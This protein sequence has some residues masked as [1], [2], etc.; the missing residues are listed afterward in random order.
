MGSSFH[1]LSSAKAAKDGLMIIGFLCALIV[2]YKK[3]WF[4]KLFNDKL[5]WLILAYGA[6]NTLLVIIK[7][8]D[9]GAELLGLVYNTRFLI[10]FLYGLMLSHLV[11]WQTLKNQAVKIVIASGFIVLVFGAVQYWLLPNDFL[12]HFGY[13]RANGVLPAFFIDDKPDL[14]RVMSTLRD[15]NS[16]GSYIIIIGLLALAY[17]KKTKDKNLKQLV[18]GITGLSVI[19]LILTFS[20]SAWLGF[21]LGAVTIFAYSHRKKISKRSILLAASL[22]LVVLTI[23]G[24]FLTSNNYFVKNVVFHADKSTKL[25]T[26]NQLRVRF[27][28]ESVA[29]IVKNSLGHGPGTAG[30][31]SIHNEIQ[32]TKLNENYYLQI[33]YEVG[34]AGLVLFL[35]ILILVGLR[36]YG[37]IAGS[38]LALGLFAAFIALIVTNFLVHIWSNEAVAYTFWGLS[39]LSLGK[40]KR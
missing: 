5:V 34:V 18:T 4:R 17:F 20:R 33:G 16:L 36:L 22:S 28:R 14:E 25:E 27:W 21:L 19:C 6:L 24:I 38:T 3:D 13:S 15:P 8:T 9:Q 37:Q 10:F 26:P 29:S 30:L 39:S 11:G 12:R 1:V 7:P 40:P 35:L 23:S 32:G 31:T 2:S